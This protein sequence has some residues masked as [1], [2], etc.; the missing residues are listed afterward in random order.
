MTYKNKYEY[1]RVSLRLAHSV[2]RSLHYKV[3]NESRPP[4]RARPQLGPT[5]GA[6]MAAAATAAS[7]C[8]LSRQL[9]A[10]RHAI[11][12][13]TPLKKHADLRVRRG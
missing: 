13:T 3:R 2:R 12:L 8:T 1:S 7:P 6:N 5:R 10:Y 9:L 4:G 11:N